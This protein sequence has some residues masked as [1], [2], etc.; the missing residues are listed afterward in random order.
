M[1]GVSL[2]DTVRARYQSES[3][4][5]HEGE[6]WEYREE[7]LIDKKSKAFVYNK[8]WFL[9][10]PLARLWI[11]NDGNLTVETNLPKLVF[12]NNA[13]LLVDPS[14]A[15]QL[16][17]E[18]I[19]DHVQG[20]RD[21]VSD[22]PYSRIDYCHNFDVGRENIPR[23]VTAFAR[24]NLLRKKTLHNDEETIS[25]Q[26]RGRMVRV[27]NK[28][29][30]MIASKSLEPQLGRG[31]L[32]LEVEIR[33]SSQV[34]NRF[35]KKG[36]KNSLIL[37]DALD[38]D[39][40]Y[41]MLKRHIERLRLDLPITSMKRAFEI[42]SREFE[43][44]K[45]MK[46]YGYYQIL[47]SHGIA[48]LKHMLPSSTYYYFRKQLMDLGLWLRCPEAEFLAPLVLPQKEELLAMHQN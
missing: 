17:D 13:R 18:F 32:R 43:G 12:G 48:K 4:L 3:K 37:R 30:E 28:E 34:L 27:Y 45:A 24:L 41:E 47:N 42:L 16:L 29:K 10:D 6:W 35:L 5:F 22:F 19:G 46:L 9:N 8:T 7:K 25:W 23:Y 44:L 31:I 38:P 33:R 2:L 39:V 40:A 21:S 1:E 11:R 36:G 20:M 26:S 14:R 15:I